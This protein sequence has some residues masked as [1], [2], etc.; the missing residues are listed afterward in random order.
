[1]L[2]STLFSCLS[3]NIYVWTIFALFSCSDGVTLLRLNKI[4]FRAVKSKTLDV[5]FAF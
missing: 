1:M 2:V 3:M 4:L 5:Y